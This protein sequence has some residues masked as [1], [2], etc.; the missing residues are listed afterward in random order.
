M[1]RKSHGFTLVELLVVITIIGILMGL[2]IPAVNAARETARRNQCAAN[3]KNLGLAAI[4][5]ENSKGALPG[6]VDK[7]GV[8]GRVDASSSPVALQPAED[9]TDPGPNG[10]Y[11]GAVPPHVKVGG[12]GVPIL[13]WL[14][15]Q[16][17]WE[18]WSQ[19]RYPIIHDDSGEL[20]KTRGGSGDSF[21][22]L[23]APNLA[24]F[25]CP[26]NPVSDGSHGKN[27]YVPNNGFAH[28]F[29][30]I[31]GSSARLI[32]PTVPAQDTNWVN[33]H[34]SD[35]GC[36]VAKYLGARSTDGNRIPSGPPVRLDD[37]KDGQGYTIFYSENLQ[38]LPWFRPGWV[39]AADV[40]NPQLITGE[41]VPGDLVDVALEKL[42]YA[43]FVNGMVWHQLDDKQAGGAAL[44]AKQHRINGGGDDVAYDP[45]VLKMSQNPLQA[46]ALAR[47]SSAHVEGVNCAFADGQTRFINST[48]DYRVYQ[49]LLTPR[50]KSSDVP[51]REFVLTDELGQ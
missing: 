24:I 40:L 44:P 7:Y 20:E 28:I 30:N 26:S 36:F 15:A 9:P 48:I 14:D 23:A 46:P 29:A 45:F 2:L 34:R 33:N 37:I 38:A 42:E 47:P 49:A 12:Y 5:Y 43:R 41:R 25:Q 22:E 27:S 21:H 17:T 50:G 18:H 13:P 10:N 8:F 39:S 32:D 35:N 4:Q 11:S 51:F 19:D 6:Y 16:P 1:K 3:I 31:P